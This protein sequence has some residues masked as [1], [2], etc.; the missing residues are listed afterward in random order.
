MPADARG[1]PSRPLGVRRPGLNEGALL[2]RLAGFLVDHWLLV[3]NTALGVFALLPFLAPV[4][5]E[6]G[7]YGPAGLIYGIYQLTCHQLPERA[8][9]IFG[10][11]MAF[12]ARN[13]AIYTTAFFVGLAYAGFQ[14][15]VP[16]LDWRVYV[17]LCV[18]MALD[19][20]TQ[21]FGWRE[22]TAAL[23]TVTGA[24]F[25]AASVW[26]IYPYADRLIALT[27]QQTRR[28]H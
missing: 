5:M 22:S 4:F 18:P 23:R 16:P 11:Q 7:W 20:L 14:R 25:G 10:Y 9:F 21:L 24:L 15:K 19:G 17:L 6:L 3:A 1:Y 26:F 12:C 13:T 2:D 28:G 27:R 8:H